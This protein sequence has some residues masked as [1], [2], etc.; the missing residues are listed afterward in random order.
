MNTQTTLVQ[1]K[2]LKLYGMAEIYKAILNMPIQE[3]PDLDRFMAR[4]AESE[5]NDR[6]LRRT[7]MYLKTSRLRYDST[8]ED[9]ICNDERNLS[10]ENL[11]SIADCSFVKRAEN[12]LITGATG[13]GKSYLACAFG[14]QACHMGLKTLYLGMNRFIE[15]VAAAKIEGSFIKLINYLER[16]ELLILDDFGLQPLDNNTRL[17]MLQILEDCNGRKSVIIT[18]Q[19]PVSKWFDYIGEPTLADAI[20]D[21]LTGKSIRVELKGSSMRQQIMKK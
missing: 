20:M 3:R 1:L 5:S 19:L 9:V 7:A 13:C 21:R 6:C 15:K 14:R 18:S 10:K 17:A 12:I 11:L 8:I 4:L 16:F 2:D